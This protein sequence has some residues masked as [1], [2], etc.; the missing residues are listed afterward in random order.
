MGF[1]ISFIFRNETD[2]DRLEKIGEGAFSNVYLG[3]S[4]INDEMVVLKVLK[5]IRQRAIN[6]EISVLK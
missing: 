6:R 4:T 2:Y 5:E 3:K 1:N